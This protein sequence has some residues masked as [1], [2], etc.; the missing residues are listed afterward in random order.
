MARAFAFGVRGEMPC[1]DSGMDALA[2]SRHSKQD[3]K[4]VSQA[5][6]SRHDLGNDS[7]YSCLGMFHKKRCSALLRQPYFG[8]QDKLSDMPAQLF[9]QARTEAQLSLS[10]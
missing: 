3:Q 2:L 4:E 6:I 8:S 10:N 7:G 9:V 5:L 1:Q